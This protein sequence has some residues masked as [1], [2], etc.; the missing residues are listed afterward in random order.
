M[1]RVVKID[2]T[3]SQHSLALVRIPSEIANVRERPLQ[4]FRHSETPHELGC[5]TFVSTKVRYDGIE[6]LAI[7]PQKGRHFDRTLV[8]VYI[9]TYAFSVKEKVAPVN[10]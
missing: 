3:F 6:V 9:Q 5:D 1:T 2:S 7:P 10:N 8:V 4:I